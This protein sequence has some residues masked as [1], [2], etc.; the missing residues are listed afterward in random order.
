MLVSHPKISLISSLPG[1]GR[2]GHRRPRLLGRR[3]LSLFDETCNTARGQGDVLDEQTIPNL[4]FNDVIPAP[5]DG[6]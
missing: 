3:D 2:D 5:G 6:S 4:Y 1:A